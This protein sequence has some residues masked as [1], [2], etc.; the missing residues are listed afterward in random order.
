MPSNANSDY[1]IANGQ[2]PTGVELDAGGI[3]D[4][5]ASSTTPTILSCR[6]RPSALMMIAACPLTAALEAHRDLRC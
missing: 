5:K 4:A 1:T 3:G 6:S 2:T